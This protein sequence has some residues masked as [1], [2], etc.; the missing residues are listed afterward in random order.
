MRR[1]G[2]AGRLM[3]GLPKVWLA[4]LN[5]LSELITDP[6]V[7]AAVLFEMACAAR[8]R[9]EVDSAQLSEVLEFADAARLWALTENEKE[10]GLGWNSSTRRI[11]C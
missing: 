10:W 9:G 5:D 1:R 11:N 2:G 3:T 4:E 7:P 8:R 6:D